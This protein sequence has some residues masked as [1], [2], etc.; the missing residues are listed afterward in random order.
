MNRIG[1]DD[2]NDDND[3]S[4]LFDCNDENDASPSNT[5][6]KTRRPQRVSQSEAAPFVTPP[7]L[8][9]VGLPALPLHLKLD[10]LRLLVSGGAEGWK[11]LASIERVLAL[12]EETEAM[13][14]AT[15][16]PSNP[17]L[18]VQGLSP[19]LR[20]SA[21]SNIKRARFELIKR[22]DGLF[23][24]ATNQSLS[25][26]LEDG[27]CYSKGER[28]ASKTTVETKANEYQVLQRNTTGQRVLTDSIA[29]CLRAIQFQFNIPMRRL[30]SLWNAFAV[31]IAASRILRKQLT[32][33]FEVENVEK[34]YTKADTEV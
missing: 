8:S 14:G 1:V 10:R 18:A 19:T 28:L 32:H 24:P 13:D 29:H 6:I 17:L 5:P 30:P 15:A 7:P 22:L 33:F 3:V 12:E 16:C 9:R 25:S 4:T 11:E 26:W 27:H 31:L 23:A 20:S 21:R 34:W 2:G